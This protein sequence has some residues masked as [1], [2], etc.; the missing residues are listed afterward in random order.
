[1]RGANQ[2]EAERLCS[3]RAHHALS[4]PRRRRAHPPD[5]P[6]VGDPVAR[7]RG[8]IGVSER[9]T[10]EVVPPRDAVCPIAPAMPWLRPSSGPWTTTPISRMPSVGASPPAA[11]PPACPAS[12]S[13]RSPRP[14]NL[15]ARRGAGSQE[16]AGLTNCPRFPE[17]WESE[18]GLQGRL[19]FSTAGGSLPS[20][21]PRRVHSESL[22][23]RLT[24]QLCALF[25]CFLF[26]AGRWMVTISSCGSRARCATDHGAAEA[27]SASPRRSF[28]HH[29]RDLQGYR[30]YMAWAER[31]SSRPSNPISATGRLTRLARRR[32]RALFRAL[33]RD[34][35][36]SSTPW[37]ACPTPPDPAAG[38]QQA[39]PARRTLPAANLRTAFP[40][41]ASPRTTARRSPSSA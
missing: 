6:P 30:K 22:R 38:F 14:R 13:P 25:R 21:P 16:D 10:I 31:S 8:A 7:S 29:F 11:P 34:Y 20:R 4:L 18:T 32:L 37:R 17:N 5:G 2:Q 1:V 26:C 19:S 9:G 12:P 33:E 15:P 24:F 41:C 35:D 36:T 27:V 28:I 23:R 40:T 3:H 39:P